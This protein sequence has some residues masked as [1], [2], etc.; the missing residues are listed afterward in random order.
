MTEC[1]ICLSEC[2]VRSYLRCGHFFHKKCLD[3]WFHS[4]NTCPICREQAKYIIQI[5]PV[6]RQLSTQDILPSPNSLQSLTSQIERLAYT[7]PPRENSYESLSNRTTLP[8]ISRPSSSSSNSS[9]SISPR[10]EYNTVDPAN[11]EIFEYRRQ[12]YNRIYSSNITFN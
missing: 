10:F 2:S 4:K 5:H 9:Y 6:N 3:T 11:R 8:I 1:P 12:E 7:R